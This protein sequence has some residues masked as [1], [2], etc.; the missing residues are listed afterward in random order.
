[1]KYQLLHILALLLIA[2]KQLAA[3]TATPNQI[4]ELEQKLTAAAGAGE[5]AFLCNELSFA[6]QKKD[7]AKSV[8]YAQDAYT[9][10]TESGNAREAMKALNLSGDAV[11]RQRDYAQ[12]EKYY[13]QALEQAQKFPDREMEARALHN[14]GKIAQQTGNLDQ[15]VQY[16]EQAYTI[17]E[18]IGDQAG[19]SS[20]VQNLAVLYGQR[21]EYEKSN[22]YYLKALQMKEAGGDRAG[23][24]TVQ[25]NL[26]NNYSALGR[27]TD[28]ELM[29]RSAIQINT[30]MGNTAG[31]AQGNINLGTVLVKTNQPEKAIQCFEKAIALYREL[32]DQVNVCGALANLAYCLTNHAAYPEA[33][34]RFLEALK[35]AETVPQAANAG[36]LYNIYQGLGRVKGFQSLFREELEYYARAL[37]HASTDHARVTVLLSTAA[38]Y[39]GDLQF[40][41]G[42]AVAQEVLGIARDKGLRESE[43]EALYQSASALI[44][45]NQVPEALKTIDKAIALAKKIRYDAILPAAMIVRGRALTRLE[46]NNRAALETARQALALA[47]KAKR[48]LEAAHA[49]EEMA[50]AYRTLNEA[51]KALEALRNSQRLRDSIFSKADIRTLAVQEK[52]HEFDKER[53]AQRREKEQLESRAAAE[54]QR[55]RSQR[56][57]WVLGLGSLLVVGLLSFFLWRNR[58][59]AHT[60]LREAETRQRIA[61]DL[62][63]DLGSTLSSISI[64]SEV[65]RQPDIGE[66]AR[67]ALESMDDIIWSVNPRN[68]SMANVLQRMKAFAVEILEPQGIAL[69]FE[70]DDAA[71]ALNLPM[72]QRKDFYLLFKE[73]VNNAAKYSGASDVW[74]TVRAG[75]DAVMLEVRDNGRGFDPGQVYR[76]NGL[77]NMERRAERMGGKFELES[78]AGAGATIRLKV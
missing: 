35:I 44:N 17:R 3:Q 25:A 23:I 55:Q 45:L 16:Y 6:W 54:L 39:I 12:A 71:A 9:A 69:H 11:F 28:A 32:G 66:K 20:T 60:Q 18:Q 31:V 68:D 53:A 61:R 46:Q 15:A 29:L 49:W 56:N 36:M 73:A 24:A 52:E 43:T 47:Q 34:E 19:L 63:D 72:E 37:P 33:Q 50:E 40:E 7:P 8:Q 70:A 75:A 10:A 77:W 51:G 27:F 2:T 64:L 58:Q 21:S 59:R 41:K 42:R 22:S 67:L 13:R 76:G 57:M 62:H 4:P 78:R 14:H 26:G 74:V 48:P 5:R 30:E 38:A 1:M 65:V